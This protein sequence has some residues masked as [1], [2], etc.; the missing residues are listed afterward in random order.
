[1]HT[2]ATT[3]ISGML[4]LLMLLLLTSQ[5]QQAA[6]AF[7]YSET[8]EIT[9]GYTISWSLVGDSIRLGIEVAD[10]TG[11]VGVGVSETG[12]MEGADIAMLSKDGAGSTW[13]VQDTHT[14]A[15]STPNVDAT[16][17]WVLVG[18]ASSS[19]GNGAVGTV[20]LEL[21]R[22]LDTGDVAQD[23]VIN[24]LE[25]TPLVFAMGASSSPGYHG[26]SSRWYRYINLVSQPDNLAIVLADPDY[27]THF[28]ITNDA[29]VIPSQVTEY[30]DLF[31]DIPQDMHGRTVIAMDGTFHN[32]ATFPYVHHFTAYGITDS[33]QEELIYVWAPGAKPMLLP[34]V[35]GITASRYPRMRITTHF[36]NPD[37]GGTGLPDISGVRFYTTAKGVA[38]QHEFGVMQFGDP[39]GQHYGRCDSAGCVGGDELPAGISHYQYDCIGLKTTGDVTI[40]SGMLHMHTKGVQMKTTHFR[41][42]KHI[43]TAELEYY[44]FDFQPFKKRSTVAKA[45]DRFVTDCYFKT[46]G[47]TKFGKE[48]LD[49]MC[50]DFVTYYPREAVTNNRCGYNVGGGKAAILGE[51]LDTL[52]RVFGGSPGQQST[53]MPTAPPTQ[54]CTD[55]NAAASAIAQQMLGITNLGGCGDDIV[56]QYCS[57]PRIAAIC[58]KAC[59]SGGDDDGAAANL[60]TT[61]DDNAA[62]GLQTGLIIALVVAITLVIAIPLA[63]IFVSQTSR[64]RPVSPSPTTRVH[65]ESCLEDG[66]APHRYSRGAPVDAS[67]GA[68]SGADARPAA[69]VLVPTAPGPDSRPITATHGS[70][71]SDAYGASSFYEEQEFVV[72]EG[73]GK[74]Q[75]KSVRRTNHAYGLERPASPCSSP[76]SSQTHTQQGMVGG[77]LYARPK[78]VADPT[79]SGQ[80]ITI[81]SGSNP[82]Y[83]EF[84]MAEANEY[85]YADWYSTVGHDAGARQ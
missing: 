37:G 79:Y 47:G 32:N 63:S 7:A 35:A 71:R 39:N 52:P 4:L 61:T 5:P 34:D 56:Q 27:D 77:P 62:T 50:V 28:D 2:L 41:G 81:S 45:G 73:S 6:G 55:D 72:K 12:G 8:M 78:S 85:E 68:G 36:N 18:T 22:K 15:Q 19:G 69:G 26:P 48:T 67:D 11:W 9:S 60:E 29:F 53:G 46:D 17:D 65:V 24:T 84:N 70:V 31:V 75:A 54:G 30:H 42:N 74:F 44:N 83:A 16:Q 59:N 1:M 40:V 33:N 58:C 80:H 38:R 3:S 14:V 25:A 82:E 57:N 51:A 10:T 64:K 21:E 20:L 66:L 43:H 49:E 76:C 23:R 13:Q